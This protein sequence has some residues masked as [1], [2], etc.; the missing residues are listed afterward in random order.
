[1]TTAAHI[2]PAITLGSRVLCS[3]DQCGEVRRI[4]LDPRA[5]RVTHL[6]VSGVD[7]ERPGWLVPIGLATPVGDSVRLRCSA[8][9]LHSL[10]TAKP[11]HVEPVGG[12][13]SGS[14]AGAGGALP[15]AAY[16]DEAHDKAAVRPGDQVRALDGVIGDAYGVVA[17]RDDPAQ[18][19]H[20]LVE[21]GPGTERRRVAVPMRWIRSLRDGVQLTMSL[22]EVREL[23]TYV[24]D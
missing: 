20:L 14:G 24:A 2:H 8:D 3:D 22:S 9:E 16:R 7:D 12:E 4:V 17:D 23:P 11:S 13:G 5:R 21:V 1:M 19:T 10:E 15:A 6:V 18:V